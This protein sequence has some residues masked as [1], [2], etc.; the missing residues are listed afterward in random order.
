[1]LLN[2]S[3]ARSGTL[4]L[5]STSGRS[6]WFSWRLVGVTL[7]TLLCGA[8]LALL[9]QADAPLAAHP[10][11]AVLAPVWTGINRPF[12]L[13]GLEAPELSKLSRTYEARRHMTGGGRQDILTFGRATADSA[14]IRLVIY[15]IGEEEV[16]NAPFFVDLARRG[17]DAGLAVTKSLPPM[18]LPTRFGDVEVADVSLTA[19]EGRALTCLGFR[20]EAKTLPWRLTGFACGG[21]K[22][23]TRPALACF[24][25]RL[26]LNT[27]GEDREL[28]AFFAETE[29]HRDPSCAGT[30]MTPAA[31][32]TR[33]LDEA[34]APVPP[35]SS[36]HSV[37]G[38]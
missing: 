13:Y 4:I 17:A 3:K 12:Q 19:A 38:F 33:L 14:Y 37:R 31:M 5:S 23:L 28:A 16:Q 6:A 24:V 7:A 18:L 21:P 35:K 1:M 20:M 29:L 36:K 11:Q 30:H 15:R 27:A 32:Q 26:D 9:A 22:P 8:G 2:S 10:E 34:P 25:D